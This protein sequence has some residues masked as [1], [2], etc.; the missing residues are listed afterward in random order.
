MRI[1]AG[2]ARAAAARCR[3][4]ARISR[5]TMRPVSTISSRRQRVEHV[6]QR[7]MDRHRHD[8]E[9]GRPQHHHR[10]APP[11]RSRAGELGQKFGVAG[12]GKAG[13]VEHVLGDRIGDDGGGTAG[14]HVGDGASI[15]PIAAAAL[16][17]SGAR[18][19]GHL[20]RQAERPAARG[21]GWRP[22]RRR[23][24]RSQRRARACARVAPRNRHR[25]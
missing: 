25:R 14:E 19:R 9:F 11:C 18:P 21:T 22:R 1:E 10:H 24:L 20:R 2:D 15:E 6:A 4:A 23:G 7:H 8:G 16:V 17:A 3:T 13:A 5:A 12:I